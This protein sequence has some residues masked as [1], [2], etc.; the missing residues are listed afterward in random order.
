MG[1]ARVRCRPM[2]TIVGEPRIDL[3]DVARAVHLY[4]EPSARCECA[5]HDG[6]GNEDAFHRSRLNAADQRNRKRGAN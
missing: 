5:V 1:I 3:S 6:D 4:G 2:G